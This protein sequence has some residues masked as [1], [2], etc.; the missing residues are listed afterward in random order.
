MEIAR[1]KAKV[2]MVHIHLTDELLLLSQRYGRI[3]KDL[4]RRGPSNSTTKRTSF[5]KKTS[6]EARK[7][8]VCV[9][10]KSPW[11][12]GHRCHKST[13]VGWARA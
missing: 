2:S 7:K 4:K 9:F 10:F 3:T 12:P 5:E 8:N 13:M 1:E 6:E 11:K